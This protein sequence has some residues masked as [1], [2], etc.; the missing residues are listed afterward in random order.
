MGNTSVNGQENGPAAGT[1]TTSNVK[2]NADSK[3]GKDLTM[4]TKEIE[5]KPVPKKKKH[6]PNDYVPRTWQEVYLQ[7][8]DW[9]LS[10]PTLRVADTEPFFV[11]GS[12]A[13]A[14]W[15]STYGPYD[16]GICMQEVWEKGGES[17]YFIGMGGHGV[18][19]WMFAAIRREA[20]AL[21]GFQV[22]YGGIYNDHEKETSAVNRGLDEMDQISR[23]LSDPSIHAAI[24][25]GQ[26][27]IA[28]LSEGKGYRMTP[29]YALAKPCDQWQLIAWRNGHLEPS[30][31]LSQLS[32]FHELWNCM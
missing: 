21:V 3:S 19:S 18:Q 28:I 24:P 31:I 1:R 16:L 2:P 14:T 15:N 8:E 12:G 10:P 27:L 6:F 29:Q 7:L 25:K 9:G 17:H 4:E 5:K 13:Y 26:V 22:P 23:C 11:I 30:N 20:R 32:V